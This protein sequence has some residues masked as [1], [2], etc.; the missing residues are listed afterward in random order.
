M[1]AAVLYLIAALTAAALPVYPQADEAGSQPADYAVAV[2][3]TRLFESMEPYAKILGKVEPGD[4]YP[5]ISLKEDQYGIPWAEVVYNGKHAFLSDIVILRERKA[6]LAKLVE[7]ADMND[8]SLWDDEMLASIQRRGVEIGITATQLLFSQGLPLMRRMRT[9]VEQETGLREWFY[10]RLVVLLQGGEVVGYTT[11]SRL[12]DDR[13]ISFELTPDGPEFNPGLGRW[14]RVDVEGF[15][16]IV[17]AG[18]RETAVF[19]LRLPVAG[20]YK[21]SA[22]W[23]AAPERSSSVSYKVLQRGAHRE[24]AKEGEDDTVLAEMH[25]NQR[26]YDKRWVYLGDFEV[27]GGA[28]LRLEISSTDR[29]PFG[30][31]S[32][33][34]EYLNQQIFPADA[35]EDIGSE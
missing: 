31:H 23:A 5:V 1:P 18:G 15:A 20:R 30:I 14:E 2:R 33:R 25:G 12:P 32:L 21:L 8:I 29:L 27:R 22:I 34:L 16:Y 9:D 6:D 28:P 19:R 13:S 26:L 17:A 24:G 4:F 10:R 35:G 3:P 11:I 7:I